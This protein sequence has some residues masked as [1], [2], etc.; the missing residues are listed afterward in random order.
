MLMRV[1]KSGRVMFKLNP[2]SCLCKLYIYLCVYF[3]K[4]GILQIHVCVHNFRS[5][6]HQCGVRKAYS[7]QFGCFVARFQVQIEHMY[8]S[9]NCLQVAFFKIFA[10]FIYIFFLFLFAPFM[11]T[12]TIQD[13]FRVY[14]NIHCLFSFICKN[15]SDKTNKIIIINKQNKRAIFVGHLHFDVCVC[16]YLHTSILPCANT[17]VNN[18][19]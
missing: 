12:D 11:L 2:F 3:Y 15:N 16:V 9:F 5:C 7:I 6:A 14:L 10:C 18:V 4:L 13:G 8:V 17:Q 19:T 1:P